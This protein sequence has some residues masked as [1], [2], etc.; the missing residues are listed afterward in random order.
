MLFS[1]LSG[2]FYRSIK[3]DWYIRVFFIGY[4]DVFFFL[5]GLVCIVRV[6]GVVCEAVVCNVYVG[7]VLVV[8]GLFVF[9]GYVFLEVD[10]LDI[11]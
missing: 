6:F 9:V 5:V 10:G 7:V 2:D 3:V 8:V 4:D 1:V 11:C